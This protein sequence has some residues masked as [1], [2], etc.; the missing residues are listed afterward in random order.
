MWLSV[1]NVEQ[2]VISY[3]SLRQLSNFIV[4]KEKKFVYDGFYEYNP[5]RPDELRY[6]LS[7][8]PLVV[9]NGFSVVKWDVF[10]QMGMKCIV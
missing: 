4:D 5:V 10:E 3:L 6:V 8:F 2:I 7:M 1:P 9:V